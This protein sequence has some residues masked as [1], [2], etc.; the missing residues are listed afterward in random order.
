MTTAIRQSKTN[1]RLVVNTGTWL[2]LLHRIDPLLGVLPPVYYSS[3]PLD[4]FRITATNDGGIPVEYDPIDK[5][6]PNDETLLQR[7]VTRT[8]ERRSVIPDRTVVD[9]PPSI[10]RSRR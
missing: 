6:D 5:P 1:D 8:P 2:K 3:Y 4:Y 10:E 9:P 7:L